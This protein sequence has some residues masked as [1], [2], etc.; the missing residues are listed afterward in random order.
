MT[1]VVHHIVQEE[2]NLKGHATPFL[3]FCKPRQLQIMVQDEFSWVMITV[4]PGQ[5]P[6]DLFVRPFHAALNSLLSKPELM[7]QSKVS[8]PNVNNPFS[9]VNNPPVNK[10]TELHHGSW[11]AD[12]WREGNCNPEKNEMLV[13]I[14]FY[15]WT[16]SL[17][18]AMED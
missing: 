2:H 5:T 10:I 9:S 18:I 14:I 12:S 6:V 16:A 13:T 4:L 8:L 7:Q 11:W 1:S 15:I 3:L 17:L